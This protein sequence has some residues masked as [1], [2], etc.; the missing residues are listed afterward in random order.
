MKLLQP[1]GLLAAIS[2]LAML[3]AQDPPSAAELEKGPG[4]PEHRYGL[5]VL[6]R[7][8]DRTLRVTFGPSFVAPVGT[9]PR[10][11]RVISTEDPQFREGVSPDKVE[12]ASAPD[13]LPPASWTGRTYARTTVTIRLPKPLK[14]GAAY[15]L[16]ALGAN[17]GAVTGGRAAAWAEILSDRAEALAA[18]DDRLGIRALEL[19]APTL[20]EITLGDGLDAARFDAHPEAVTIRSADDPDVGAGRKAARAGRR[21][22][23]ECFLP[24]GWPFGYFQKHELFVVLDRPLKVGKTYEID[25]NAVMPLVSGRA[26]AALV[27]DERSNVNPALKVNQVGYLPEAAAKFG[28]LGAWMGSLGP[29]DF[30]PHAPSFEVR[31][32]STHRVVLSGKPAPRH[33]GGEASETPYKLDLSGEDVLEL[34]F[35]ELRAPGSYYVAVPGCGRS[36]A[37]RVAR[38]IYVHPFRVLMNGV[39]HQ[40]CGIELGPPLSKHFRPACHRNGTELT[41]LVHGSEQEAFKELPNHVTSGGKKFDF[42]GGHHDAGDYNPRSHLDVA[43]MAFLAYELRP[44]AYRDGQLLVPEGRNGVP[45]LLDEGRWALDL[46]TRLQDDDG[47]VRNGTESNGDPDQITLPEKDLLRDF[48]FAKDERGSLRF[49]S[50]AA[51]A[52]ILW[53]RIGKKED[54]AAFLN[55]AKKAWAW[56]ER[57]KLEGKAPD[58]LALAAIQLYR[59][60]GEGAFREAFEKVSVFARLADADLDSYGKY[61]QREASFYYAICERPVDEAVRQKILRAYKQRLDFWIRSAESTAYRCFKH[62]WV[63]FNWGAGAFPNGLLDLMEGHALLK[64]PAYL[65]WIALSC[66]FSLGCH[67]MGT[68]FTTRLGQRSI[69]GPLHMYSRYSP[70]GPIAGIQCEGPN[71]ETGGKKMA[72]DMGTWIGAMLYPAGAWPAL[73]T[74]SDV[75]MLPSMCEGIVSNQIRTAIAYGYLLPQD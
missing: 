61:D 25:L 40:R 30:V 2:S 39:L 24:A 48:A 66:D 53:N 49:A 50:T 72:G 8:D 64:D 14:E 47:G 65:K 42:Y 37:F 13:V 26:R 38:D 57:L 9:Q 68:V 74:Y 19:I 58:D 4:G 67:P 1:L 5:R 62:P 6:R 10:T 45:D 70:S 63:P 22:R 46:W 43:Q 69:S 20:L 51:Q 75:S 71:A 7:V 55:R 21:S 41:D 34:D 56:V 16:Q 33:K 52:S 18:G 11:Y 31:D 3:P 29:F 54:A 23:G 36:F 17:G 60:T 73:Q 28:Y 35:S 12:I 15:G 32:A 44:G 59:A 27:V